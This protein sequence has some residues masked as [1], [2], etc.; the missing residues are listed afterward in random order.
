MIALALLL[1][2]ADPVALAEGEPAPFAG[3]LVDEATA[4]EVFML[5]AETRALRDR[6]EAQKE[7]TDAVEAFWRAKLEEATK[8][9]DVATSLLDDPEANRWGG[10]VVGFLAGV[11][12]L[13]GGAWVAGTVGGT[14]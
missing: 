1:A 8:R 12:V 5:R 7:I 13:A 14:E 11:G 2:M 6:V 9:P 4:R 10:F 3:V